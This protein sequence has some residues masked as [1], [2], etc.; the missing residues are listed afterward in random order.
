MGC[1]QLAE[2]SRD[3]VCSG[4]CLVQLQLQ[5]L[6]QGP[7]HLS[8]QVLVVDSFH[9]ITSCT[10]EVLRAFGGAGGA[11]VSAPAVHVCAKPEQCW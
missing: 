10:V 2:G 7:S 6:P 1:L 9:T 5:V 8:H 11:G 4:C 3:V